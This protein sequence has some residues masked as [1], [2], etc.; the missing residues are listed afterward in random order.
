MSDSDSSFEDPFKF[1]EVSHIKLNLHNRQ[2][3]GNT[4]DVFEIY[5]DN[6]GSSKPELVNEDFVKDE[7]SRLPL[8]SLSISEV[9]KRRHR[10]KNLRSNERESYTLEPSLQNKNAECVQRYAGRKL[11]THKGPVMVQEDNNNKKLKFDKIDNFVLEEEQVY[12]N[13]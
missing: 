2:Q 8:K 1:H 10:K 4:G 5:E 3:I 13:D 9:R 7:D 6:S 11:L 12:I